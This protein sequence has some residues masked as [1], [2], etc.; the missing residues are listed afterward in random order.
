MASTSAAV[1]PAAAVTA[2]YGCQSLSKEE[3][4]ASA[5][6]ATGGGDRKDAM[7]SSRDA[8]AR[9]LDSVRLL[10]SSDAAS[11]R[12]GG[13]AAC[14]AAEREEVLPSSDGGGGGGGG[15]GGFASSARIFATVPTAAKGIVT[16]RHTAAPM[17]EPSSASEGGGAGAE[18][19]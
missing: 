12:R 14:G 10:T 2:S 1:V 4:D 8:G 19:A 15:S 6:R 5:D 9:P 13:S 18:D 16:A 17:P 7:L 3:G 11:A